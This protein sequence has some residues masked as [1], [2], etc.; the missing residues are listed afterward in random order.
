MTDYHLCNVC[1]GN[2]AF[3]T[4]NFDDICQCHK[5]AD[6]VV[7]DGKTDKIKTFKFL[8]EN[9]KLCARMRDMAKL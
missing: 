1:H 4:L 5:T 2:G 7:D 9:A 8:S 6:N 3:A